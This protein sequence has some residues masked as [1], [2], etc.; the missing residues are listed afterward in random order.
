LTAPARST[1][2]SSV[3]CPGCSAVNPPDAA[4]C[5]ACDSALTVASLVVVAGRLPERVF[6]LRPRRYSVGRSHENDLVLTEPS[7][8]KSHAWLQYEAGQFTVVDRDSLHGVYLNG[9][10]IKKA[11]LTGGCE[12]A[13]G[14]VRLRF[15]EG[16]PDGIT[17]PK[18]RLPWIEHQQLLLSL[19]QAVNASLDLDEVLDRVLDAVMRVTSAERGFLL[20]ANDS[21]GPI[22]AGLN[23]RLGRRRD[24]TELPL[25]DPGLSSSIIRK[26]LDSQELVATS[27]ASADPKLG[28]ADSIIMHKLRSIVCIPLRSAP[29]EQGVGETSAGVSVLGALYVDNPT[30]PIPFSEDTLA[31]ASA[32]ARHA[33]LAIQNAQLFA[34]VRGMLEQLKQAQ[35]QLLQSEKLATIGQMASAIVHELNTPLT[36]IVG[37][38]ELMLGDTLL[39][40][41]EERLRQ[42]QVGA[43]KIESLTRNLLAFSRPATEERKAVSLNSVVE[44]GLELCRYQIIKAGVAVEKQL[45]PKLPQI[46]GLA[47]QLE[48][49][50]INLVVNALHAMSTG[51]KL[52]VSTKRLDDKVE[53]RVSDNGCGIPADIRESIFQPFVTTRPEGQGTGLGLSTVARVVEQHSGHVDFSTE[54]GRGTTFQITFPIR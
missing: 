52:V 10:K 8:S 37:C 29:M 38:V 3:E 30:T 12:M 40:G 26:A 27:N 18:V 53:V 2:I 7:V 33:A 41:Q 34:S 24:G 20:L 17:D 13:F 47:S 50:V 35:R 15:V 4:R 32:L 14:N 48:M 51:G 19:V 16:G 44:R 25:E 23:L 11:A 5:A 49:A 6:F 43:E 54:E 46:S 28:E 42:V 1:I 39:P 22:V 31:A 21:S 9:T 45:D 36:Y